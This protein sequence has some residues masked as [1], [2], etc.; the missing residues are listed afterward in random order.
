MATYQDAPAYQTYQTTPYQLPAQQ[1]VQA[2]ATR[3]QYWEGAVSSLKNVYQNYLGL[4]LSN[5]Q[6][7]NKL[8]SLMEGVNDNLKKATSTDLSIGENYGK[9]MSIFDPITKDQNIMGDNA[10]TKD[11]NA[12]MQVGMQARTDK[13]GASYNEYS[14]RELQ[15]H[16]SDFSKA[17]P[18]S[19]RDFYNNRPVYT[20]YVDY[21]AEKRSADK[22][23]KPDTTDFTTPVTSR[24]TVLDENG[25]EKKD[26]NGNTVY[27]DVPTGYMLN[28]RDKS[29]LASQY[30]AYLKSSM[31]SKAF[32]QM[33]LEGRVAYHNRTPDLANDYS[34]QLNDQID[35]NKL[36]MEIL[37]SKINSKTATPAQKDVFNDQLNR[38]SSDVEERQMAQT[39]IKAG[40]YS[41]L[42]DKSQLA[43]IV[44]TNNLVDYMSRAA[45]RKDVYVKYSEDKYATTMAIQGMENSRLNATLSSREREGALDREGRLTTTMLKLGYTKNGKIT[46]PLTGAENYDQATDRNTEQYSVDEFNKMKTKSEG[47]YNDALTRLNGLVKADNPGFKN[48]SEDAKAK[49]LSDWGKEDKNKYDFRE[50]TDAVHSHDMDKELYNSVENFVN[51][52]IKTESP[53]IYNGKQDVINSIKNG[54]TVMLGKSP[55]GYQSAYNTT[56][57]DT[58]LKLSSDELKSVLNDTNPNIKLSTVKV[59]SGAAGPGGVPSEGNQDVLMVNGKPYSFDSKTIRSSLTQLRQNSGNFAEERGKILN[60]NLTRITGRKEFTGDVIKDPQAKAIQQEA[61][62]IVMGGNTGIGKGE[63]VRVTAMTSDGGVYVKLQGDLAKMDKKDIQ[64]NV[65]GRGGYYSE[66]NQEYFI[67]GDKFG[68]LTKQSYS[69]PRLATADRVVRLR[70]VV[71]PNDRYELPA[72]TFG[73]HHFA[74]QVTNSAGHP[75]YR[76]LDKDTGAQFSRNPQTQEPFQNLEQLSQVANNMG[77][78]NNEDYTNL[79]K[80]IGGGNK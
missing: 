29:I 11:H 16:I 39:K 64:K 25:A 50:W 80:T 15:N 72:I 65:E 37:R 77:S 27:R 48:L 71:N 69:D 42:G 47:D 58:P 20:P 79:V 73:S 70:S 78:L 34:N 13:G 35:S 43:G 74:I 3:N 56:K 75:S 62:N 52:K 33:E 41:G 2:I 53:G 45:A 17:D 54:E 32:G 19:W 61:A 68:P 49:I 46:T 67:P 57:F 14:M 23:F 30:R 26:A 7:Q 59:T 1:M 44:H 38:L 36:E 6:N 10:I 31:S 66:G 5:G 9:A 40:D 55:E 8:N 63:D 4:Q 60:Q 51:N 24:Q 21:M 76:L 28:T 12:Q 22:N 18:N